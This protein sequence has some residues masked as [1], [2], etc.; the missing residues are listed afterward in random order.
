MKRALVGLIG[1]NIQKSL[2]PRLHE[3]AFAAAGLRGN[4]VLLDVDLLPGQRIGDLLQA[5]RTLGF[6]GLNVTLPCKEAVVPLLDDVSAEARQIGAVNTVTIDSGGRTMGH[7]TDRAGFRRSFEEGLGRAAVAGQAVVL[8]GAGGAGRAVAFAL[9]DLGARRVL[10][11]DK[12]TQRS[13][14]L[15]AILAEAFGPGRSQALQAIAPALSEAAGVVNATPIGMLGFPGL[16]V[17]IESIASRH[18][19]ADVIYTP[20]ET[21]LIRA[22]RARGARVL[23]GGGMCVYQ[24][25]EAFRLFTGITPD[26]AR[27]KR[28]FAEAAAARDS[29]LSAAGATA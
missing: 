12:D 27:M 18:F 24:A 2:S 1:A 13:A 22:A 3:D 4:Y 6:T 19:V 7:N 17:P 14:A 9:M 20:L 5:A 29:A 10:V 26:P 15:A 25:A 28:V 23:T 11:Y 16:P 8:V 21:E